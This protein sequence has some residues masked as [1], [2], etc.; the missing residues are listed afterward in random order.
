MSKYKAEVE[1]KWYA[2]AE[3]DNMISERDYIIAEKDKINVQ[4]L[5][6]LE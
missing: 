5:A 2:L 1:E 6:K 3:K 4:N